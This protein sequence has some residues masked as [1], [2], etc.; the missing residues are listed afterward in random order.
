MIFSHIASAESLKFYK[1]IN[2]FSPLQNFGPNNPLLHTLKDT[3]CTNKAFSGEPSGCIVWS[4]HCYLDRDSSGTHFNW[5]AEVEA[6]VTV[7]TGA[8]RLKD[9]VTW[10]KS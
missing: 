5:T 7:N 1:S 9:F 10:L 4:G 6:G 3:K 2:V 8:E